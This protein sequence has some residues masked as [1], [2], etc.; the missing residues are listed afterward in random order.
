MDAL[1][2]ADAAGL[3]ERSYALVPRPATL[4]NLALADRARGRYARAIGELERF[5][6]TASPSA[7]VRRDAE[8]LL[9]EM[10]SRVATLVIDTDPPA[11]HVSVDGVATP[12]DVPVTLDPGEHR[13][14]AMGEGNSQAARGLSLDA[15]ERRRLHLDLR[16][17][18][19]TTAGA[20][21]APASRGIA[22]RWWF[23]ST[24]G[25][26][27]TG[28]VVAAVALRPASQGPD[29]GTLGA[30]LELP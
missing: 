25:V 13:V 7:T 5:L 20:R 14:L 19:S 29:C 23:W 15:G 2:W 3:F 4:R 22:S 8:Q 9:S 27:V 6:A 21:V 11:A 24:I 10:R 28:A 30:C 1:R 16:P 17:A 12:S 18:A 26:V